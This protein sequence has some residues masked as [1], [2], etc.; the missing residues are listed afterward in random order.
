MSRV[1]AERGGNSGRLRP[2]RRRRSEGWKERERIGNA[3]DC[4]DITS[5][6]CLDITSDWLDIP[7]S[8]LHEHA[9]K[10]KILVDVARVRDVLPV[11][12]ETR[13]NRIGSNSE[14]TKRPIFEVIPGR[15]NEVAWRTRVRTT[16][17][18]TMTRT[19]RGEEYWVISPR[20][21]THAL[22]LLEED[23]GSEAKED[24]RRFSE[25]R[26]AI[27]LAP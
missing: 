9:V 23:G 12:M 5:S 19:S 22:V 18:I 14:W 21:P 25:R 10:A 1:G 2:A 6:H 26:D 4:L 17:T 20:R 13:Q 16:F 15:A 24:L 27:L 7:S 8:Q 3:V 11:T